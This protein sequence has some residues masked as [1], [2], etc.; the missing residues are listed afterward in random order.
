MIAV[1]NRNNKFSSVLSYSQLL[2]PVRTLLSKYMRLSSILVKCFFKA[3]DLNIFGM[4][5]LQRVNFN[6]KLALLSQKK[7]VYCPMMTDLKISD[8]FKAV[9]IYIYLLWR[10]YILRF[11]QDSFQWKECQDIIQS[12]DSLNWLKDYS[13]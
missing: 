13:F 3:N 12:L 5:P 6:K 11:L 9:Y 10:D 8:G 2:I 1:Q 4:E 7:C